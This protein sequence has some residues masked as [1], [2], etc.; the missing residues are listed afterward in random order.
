MTKDALFKVWASAKGKDQIFFHT[1]FKKW[2]DEQPDTPPEPQNDTERPVGSDLR[3][4]AQNRAE[5][6]WFRDV[7]KACL[8]QGAT[9]QDILRPSMDLQ[10]DEGFIKWMFRRIGKKKYGKESTADHTKLEVNAIQDELINFFATKVDPPIEL[11]PWPHDPNKGND[12]IKG[13]TLA[14]KLDYPDDI[15]QPNFD[16]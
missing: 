8:E 13:I 7:A 16:V 12:K 10:V 9:I 4:S 15:G 14:S 3:T 6:A 5:H 11:P 2:L 1:Y